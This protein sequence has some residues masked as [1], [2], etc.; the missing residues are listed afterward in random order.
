MSERPAFEAT[1][2]RANAARIA[3]VLGEA[4]RDCLWQAYR[5][6]IVRRFPGARLEV[7]VGRGRATYCQLHGPRFVINF[8][9]LMVADKIDPRWAGSWF[10]TREVQRRGYLP[11]PPGALELLA[12][13]VC[14]EFAHVLRQVSGPRGRGTAHDAAFYRV[15]DALHAA[16]SFARVR[17]FIAERL[18]AAGIALS[19]T[20]LPA[21]PARTTGCG[22]PVASLRRGLRVCFAAR[23]GRELTG[24]ILRVNRSTVSVLPLAAARTGTWYRVPFEFVRVI[25]EAGA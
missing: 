17:A 9:A 11:S 5:T 21:G 16:G 10:T 19:A 23:A 14:H 20:P 13:T 8:G 6:E 4:A 12:H 15:L 7:R 1:A 22:R 24:E 25:G 2:A 3:G 18:A